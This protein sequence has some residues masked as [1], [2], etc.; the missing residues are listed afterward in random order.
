MQIYEQKWLPEN[1]Q[2]NIANMKYQLPTVSSTST[3]SRL[4]I[5]RRAPAR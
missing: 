1:R 3:S 2:I 5:H 4:Q